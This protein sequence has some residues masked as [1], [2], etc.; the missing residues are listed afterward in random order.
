[1]AE[2]DLDILTSNGFSDMLF[3][4][5]SYQPE[6]YKYSHRRSPEQIKQDVFLSR[7]VQHI[8]AETAKDKSQTVA[9]VQEEAKA[10]LDEMG[11]N[12]SLKT[13]R[14]MAYLLRKILTSLFR[15][16]KEASVHNPVVLVPSHRSYMDFLLVSFICFS[17]DLPLPFI[18]AAQDF[19]NM[20]VVRRLFRK[21]GAFFMRRSFMADKLYWVIFTEYVQNQL[22]RG[23]QPLEFFLEG[24][25]SRTGKFLHPRLGLLSMV[26]DLYANAGVPNILLCPI[27]ISYERVIEEP[28]FAYE[29]LG[30]PKPRESLRGLIKSRSVL[31]EDYGSIYVN[32]GDL[33]PLSSCIE[34]KL[35]RM[36][37]AC[38]PRHLLLYLTD[39]EKEVVRQLGYEITVRLQ[40]HMVVTPSVTVAAIMLQNQQ[41]LPLGR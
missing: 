15:K 20:R 3:G 22:Q 10:I 28:L 14:F 29:L 34:G 38:I 2:Y 37:T 33:I 40:S 19:M 12:F 4:L 11:H 39:E 24:T 26:V 35:D 17:V 41:G 21:S 6:V 18:A 5:K 25:R 32:F 30:I 31:Y 1:M 9:Q 16:L 13:I 8:I 27:S 7:R 36:S 23:E